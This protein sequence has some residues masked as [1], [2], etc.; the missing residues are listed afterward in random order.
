MIMTLNAILDIIESYALEAG[1]KAEECCVRSKYSIQDYWMCIEFSFARLH[2]SIAREAGLSR[3]CKH[4]S[5]RQAVAT[6]RRTVINARET[7]VDCK[8]QPL[9]DKNIETLI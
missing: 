5:F 1:A 6:F 9:S 7:M 3:K 4:S 8:Q 2:D